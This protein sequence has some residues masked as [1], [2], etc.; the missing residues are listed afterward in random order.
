MIVVALSVVLKFAAANC[1]ES[2]REFAP[3]ATRRFRSF[4]RSK[5]CATAEAIQTDVTG[6][7]SQEFGGH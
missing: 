4:R 6:T 3:P 5:P 2:H 1:R 7:S